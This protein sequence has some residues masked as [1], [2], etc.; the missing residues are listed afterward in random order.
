MR[1]ER[2][3]WLIVFCMV[4]LV[5]HGLLGYSTKSYGLTS[6]RPPQRHDIEITLQS[7]PEQKPA[8]P[9]PLSSPV[10]KTTPAEPAP[11]P[12][13]VPAKINREVVREKPSVSKTVSKPAKFVQIA[14]NT[15]TRHV[16][17]PAPTQDNDALAPIKA[18]P[19][20]NRAVQ[21]AE[22]LASEAP[23]PQGVQDAPRALPSPRMAAAPKTL[24]VPKDV[25]GGSLAP[26][27]SLTGKGGAAGP[28]ALPEDILYTGGGAGGANLPKAPAKIGGGGG[29][30]ILSVENPLAKEAIPESKPGLGPGTGGG[31]GTGQG[32]GAGFKSGKGIGTRRDGQAALATLNSKPGNGIGAGEGSNIGTKA[33]GGGKGTGA[34]MPGT[35]GEGEGY[36][37]GKGIG[38]GNEP[39]DQTA[40]SRGIPFGNIAGLLRGKSKDGG[41]APGGALVQALTARGGNA[42]IHIIYVLDTSGS[43][44]DG[45][46]IAKAKDA[47]CRAL[48]ELRSTDYFN[49][50]NFDEH[51]HMMSPVMQAATRANVKD[52]FKFVFELSLHNYTNVSEG[53]EQALAQEG[54]THIFLLSD[55]EPNKG[56]QQFS[57]L[58]AFI[59]EHNTKGVQINTLAL[60]LGE[61]FPGMRLL[62]GIAEDNGGQYGY[63]N[64][65]NDTDRPGD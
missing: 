37:R 58:R 34:E 26:D 24:A 41:G 23:L 42:P 10:A 9:K 2:W 30:S 6:P 61:R 11:K 8:P 52:A 43:M 46:K 36:G 54:V 1:F 48:L 40:L 25:G 35:G 7:G 60:G 63:V 22:K 19:T 17:L 45:G 16:R 53:M 55:G 56:V 14:R 5:V 33:P 39:N 44:R 28:E 49:V 59:K 15:E 65:L 50:I 13:E 51:A 3:Y 12:E 18:A 62:N 57:Q 47:L 21:A 29:N 31:A 4:S 32:G 38:I 20:P 64:L 27:K